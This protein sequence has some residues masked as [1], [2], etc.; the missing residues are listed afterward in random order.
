MRDWCKGDIAY[1]WATQAR[2]TWS[3][4]PEL[5]EILA[6]ISYRKREYGRAIQLLRESALRSPLDARALF[7]LGMSQLQTKQESE[8]RETLELALAAALDEPWETEAKRAIKQLSGAK[9]KNHP[10]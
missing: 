1:E 7:F 6:E 3:E 4:D 9:L 10:R 2:E 8:G 5:T